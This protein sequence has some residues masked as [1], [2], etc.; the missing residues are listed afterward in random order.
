MRIAGDDHVRETAILY[1]ILTTGSGVILDYDDICTLCEAEPGSPEKEKKGGVE[2]LS[3]KRRM[4]QLDSK[5]RTS[6]TLRRGW[7]PVW[8]TDTVNPGNLL[9]VT[10]AGGRE[11][12]AA[13]CIKNTKEMAH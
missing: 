12:L 3:F 11:R 7:T 9:A 8:R 5:R 13:K 10:H 2:P 1:V 4:L 6:T